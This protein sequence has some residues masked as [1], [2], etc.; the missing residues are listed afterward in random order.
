MKELKQRR[1]IFLFLI[2]WERGFASEFAA[3][4]GR[5]RR[6]IGVGMWIRPHRPPLTHSLSRALV[7]SFKPVGL[8]FDDDGKKILVIGN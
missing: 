6:K 2:F 1:A 4:L 5:R 7:I 8:A 3:L